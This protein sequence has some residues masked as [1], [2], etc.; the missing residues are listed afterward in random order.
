MGVDETLRFLYAVTCCPFNVTD[1]T[2]RG[3]GIRTHNLSALPTS[4]DLTFVANSVVM[5]APAVPFG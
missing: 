3:A 5:I 2:N 1:V 4:F